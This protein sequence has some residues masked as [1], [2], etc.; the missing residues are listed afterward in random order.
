MTREEKLKMTDR[1]KVLYCIEN[2][3]DVSCGKD[4]CRFP[5]QEGNTGDCCIVCAE[6]LLKRV[7]DDAYNAGV[8]KCAT[9]LCSR[10][11]AELSDIMENLNKAEVK[12]HKYNLEKW[13]RVWKREVSNRIIT[14][15]IHTSKD[16]MK[17]CCN[18]EVK[19]E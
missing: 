13:L 18:N 8:D 16:T 15:I 12:S 9:T 19:G 2:D 14:T 17:R 5:E 7:E 4:T 11:I 10:V 3:V 1:E 6:Q